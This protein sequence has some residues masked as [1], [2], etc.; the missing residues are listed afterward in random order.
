MDRP[1]VSVVLPVF[2]GERYLRQSIESCLSQSYDCLELIVVDDGSTDSTPLIIEEYTKTDKRA[3]VLSHACNRGLPHALNSGFAAAAGQY[4]TW[5]SA[6]NYYRRHA[7]ARMLEVLENDSKV[8]FIYSDYSS[9]DSQ[10]RFLEYWSVGEAQELLAAN[11]IGPCFL[12]RQE[13]QKALGRYNEEMPL[14]E[15]YDFWLRAS[16]LFRMVPLHEDLYCYRTHEDS[17]TARLRERVA[18]IA[19]RCLERNL[20][21]LTWAARPDKAAA[22]LILARRAQLRGER[23]HAWRLAFKAFRLAPLGAFRFLARRVLR[24][25]GPPPA[26]QAR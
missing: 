26:A 22:Y 25:P 4:F 23:P 20:P 12:Y 19:D 11:R 24:L 17:L 9:T 21:S 10:N 15:D 7:I 14:A 16:T 13:V 3:R 2:N 18:V 6:D 8:D 5:T 1:L